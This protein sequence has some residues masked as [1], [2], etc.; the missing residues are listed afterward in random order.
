MERSGKATRESVADGWS[1]KRRKVTFDMGT[2]LN[3][4]A[5]EEL[6]NE[7]IAWLMTLPSGLVRDHIVM[8]L[9]DYVHT[10]YDD[11]PEQYRAWID[12]HAELDQA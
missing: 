3:R 10:L 4:A 11:L 12:E 2:T 1:R 7:N 5:F 9:K 8:C 6:N